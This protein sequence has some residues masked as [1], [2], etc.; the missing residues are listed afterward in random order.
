MELLSRLIRDKVK[1]KKTGNRYDKALV[2]M[3]RKRFNTKLKLNNKVNSNVAELVMAHKLPGA[4][5]TY[6]KPTLREVYDAIKP[7][8]AELTIDPKK[9]QRIIIEAKQKKIDELE[10]KNK[11]IE[12]L[13][14]Q[15]DSLEQRTK[16]EP[17]QMDK[18]SEKVLKMIKANPQWQEN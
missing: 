1:R 13:Q 6:T 14:A 4:Q 12:D 3:W 7:A 17:V 15:M 16:L 11:T 9:R 2:T 18:L 8:F 5:G 10:E